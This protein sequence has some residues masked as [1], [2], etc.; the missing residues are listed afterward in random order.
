[1]VFFTIV[2]S[3]YFIFFSGIEFDSNISSSQKIKDLDK[4]VFW[5]FTY[6]KPEKISTDYSV[7]QI[8]ND[9]VRYIFEASLSKKYI[10]IGQ[11]TIDQSTGFAGNSV[12]IYILGNRF[13]VEIDDYSDNVSDDNSNK[14]YKIL[15]QKIILDKENYQI[16]DSI[17]GK[18]EIKFRDNKD[19]SINESSGFFRGK[20]H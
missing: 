4:K 10:Y 16:N 8:G 11:L 9:T 2:G 5:D 7:N 14:G 12:Y 6:E 1:M 13:K 15:S 3:L 19:N 17:F 20:V 18:I